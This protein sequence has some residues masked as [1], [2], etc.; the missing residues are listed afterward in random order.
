MAKY[1]AFISY[2]QKDKRWAKRIHKAIETYKV[3]A[4]LLIDTLDKRRRLGKVFLDTEEK[5]PGNHIDTALKDAL[6]GSE[7]LIV[8]CS[9]NAVASRFVDEEIKYFKATH[10]NGKI[11]PVIV[12]GEPHAR[13]SG[14]EDNEAFPLALISKALSRIC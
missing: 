6:E 12:G 4:G 11:L 3:P 5:K 10:P 8:L 7:S 14:E 2:S 9:P 13:D 1:R